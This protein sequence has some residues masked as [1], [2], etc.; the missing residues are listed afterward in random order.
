MKENG[1]TN[2]HRKTKHSTQRGGAA[3]EKKTL[4]RRSQSFLA[5]PQSS[6]AGFFAVIC[7]VFLRS[8]R[9]ES[10]LHAACLWLVGVFAAASISLSQTNAIPLGGTIT[11]DG[12]GGGRVF[13]GIG[14][15][16]AGASSRLLIDYR[17]PYRSQI[18]DY[19]FKPNYGAVLQHLKVEIGGDENSTDGSEPSIARTR[20]EMAHPNFN[21]G[22]E[23]WLME[24]AK[25]RNPKI[26]LDS[27][28]WGAPGWI[29][30][31]H[32]YSQDMADYVVKFLQGGK[33][34]HNLDI[35]YTGIW[36]ETND[37]TSYV[38]LLKRTLI[39]HGLSTKLV[40]CD[41]YPSENQWSIISDMQRD[42]ELKGAVDVVSVHYPRVNGKLTTPWSAKDSGKPLWSSEDQP[43]TPANLPNTR[44]WASGGRMLAELYNTNYIEG[45][46]TKTETWSPITS[47]YD[48]LAAPHSGLMYANTPW[49]GHY[50]VQSAL[51][52]TA[53]TTQFAQP[54]WRYIDSA[55][56][57]LAG[58]GS[59]VSL[60][61]PGGR[62]FSVIVETIEAT[63]PQDVTFHLTGSLAATAVHV[64]ETNSKLNFEHVRDITP[65]DGSWEITL[66]PDS[67]YTFTTTTG[68]HKGTV[69]S[70]PAAP[71]PF[72][73]VQNFESTA[74]GQSPR[75]FADQN[76]AFEARPCSGRPGRC[77]EQVILQKPIAWGPA[78]DPYTLLG[79]VNW[80]DY[81][82]SVDVLLEQP[83]QVSLI[84]R[85]DDG[86]VFKDQKAR[87]PGGYILLVDQ[88]GS[89][90]L[91]SAKFKVPTVKLASG[92][93]PFAM[94]KWHKLAMRFDGAGIEAL[95]DGVVV[96]KAT[97]TNNSQGMVGIGCG[98]N[99]AQFDNFGV[100]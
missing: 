17:E 80:R 81:T 76:G 96:I 71:F 55:C 34:A 68:Q 75:F 73:Y 42:P 38:K 33:S 1:N 29:G 66:D 22:Y 85:I 60:R 23:W 41:L 32:F 7:T 70:P 37:D 67:L 10:F 40:C 18:L 78:P 49:S 72:P 15:V 24:E 21:R 69:L 59:Y 92:K 87:W 95:I 43:L 51:W 3:T 13:E 93:V 82:V 48:I 62:D 98:W 86:D 16:S 47:Y 89:W 12:K 74:V 91:N 35:H 52:V 27:L 63:T 84:G 45:S 2:P 97:D 77:L 79:S 83:G 8:L 94:K 50:D 44:D 54:G 30:N 90:E 31:G 65:R 100:R 19:L 20:E 36:N 56:G 4:T 9:V 5:R 6:D 58:K 61:S 39:L 28:A 26:M 46:F 25:K 11:I 99:R 14:S 57:Y 53:H 64:W 88:D